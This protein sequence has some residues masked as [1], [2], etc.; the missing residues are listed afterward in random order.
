MNSVSAKTAIAIARWALTSSARSCCQTTTA[1]STDCTMT[2]RPAAAAA[3]KSGRSRRFEG[4]KR[5]MRP[6]AAMSGPTAS[7]AMRRCVCSIQACSSAGGIQSLNAKQPGQSGHPRPESVART[8]PPALIRTKV[9]T[10]AAMAS[11]AK[12]VKGSSQRRARA[13]TGADSGATRLPSMI[14][15]GV[16]ASAPGEAALG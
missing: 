6:T 1:P 4:V 5:V 11:L 14:P 13:R 9:A 12:R 3:A 8:S 15:D 2:S 16:G 10:A 7:A